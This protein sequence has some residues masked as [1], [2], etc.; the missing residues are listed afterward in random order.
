MKV[1]RRCGECR[2]ARSVDAANVAGGIPAK[3][4]REIQAIPLRDSIATMP[5]LQEIGG[6][7]LLLLAA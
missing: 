1:D 7:E 6:I 4:A 2:T 5:A 3:S